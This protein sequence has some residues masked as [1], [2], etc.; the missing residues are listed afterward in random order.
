MRIIEMLVHYLAEKEGFCTG[1]HV[2]LPEQTTC[3]PVRW[4]RASVGPAT[5]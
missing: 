4:Q 2:E 1:L 3:Q 5:L